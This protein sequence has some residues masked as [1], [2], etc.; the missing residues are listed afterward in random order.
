ML[1]P[2]ARGTVTYV[3]EA[4]SYNIDVSFEIIIIYC[5]FIFLAEVLF[6]FEY[7]L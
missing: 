5:L 4:G 7:F 1:H 6:L 2:K 3:A